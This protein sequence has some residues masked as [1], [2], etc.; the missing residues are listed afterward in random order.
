ML[1]I[2]VIILKSSGG[3]SDVRKCGYAKNEHIP[4]FTY[5]TAKETEPMLI[6]A[7]MMTAQKNIK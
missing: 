4:T 7:N 1:P 2:A 6:V 3:L 5:G